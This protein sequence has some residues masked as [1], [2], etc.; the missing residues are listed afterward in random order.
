MTKLNDRELKT[1]ELSLYYL[2]VDELKKI[3]KSLKLEAKG[4][5]EF[6][7]Q[8]ILHFLKTDNILKTPKIP[9][10]SKAQK[11]KYYKIE[12]NSLILKGH[13]KNDLKTR[14]FFK[15][16]IGEHF[17]F[18][19]YGIDWINKKWLDGK[20]PTYQEYANYWQKE[21]LESQTSKKAPKKEWA[22]INFV[23]EYAKK[24]PEA[25]KVETLQAWS[26]E[27]EKHVQIVKK[28]LKL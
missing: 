23:L 22:L 4:K 10:C 17:H 19:A 5:K 18:T 9:E 16:L 15:K 2:K 25:N 11:C 6:L 8:S 7:I 21:Y 26:I 1:L 20:P 3:A 13:Y 28:L 27:R 24:Y 12:P 14:N